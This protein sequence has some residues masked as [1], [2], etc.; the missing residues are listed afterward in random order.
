MK[1]LDYIAGSN[2]TVFKNSEHYLDARRDVRTPGVSH[3][4][5]VRNGRVYRREQVSD[6]DAPMRVVD[7]MKE[8]FA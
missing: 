8:H 4:E 3:I 5:L 2:V 1:V 6:A 7:L